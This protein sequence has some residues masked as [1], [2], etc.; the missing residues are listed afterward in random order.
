[1]EIDEPIIS[2]RMVDDGFDEKNNVIAPTAI[3]NSDELTSVQGCTTQLVAPSV[4][5]CMSTEHIDTKE[6]K[7]N[8][9]TLVDL[10]AMQ[11]PSR[12]NA[13]ELIQEVDHGQQ[14]RAC[15]S[16]GTG[17]SPSDSSS[18]SSEQYSSLESNSLS[19]ALE[20]ESD[21]EP[22]VSLT[23]VSRE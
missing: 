15:P 18:S 7:T 19:S 1:M 10:Q 21:S 13:Q 20:F 17:T 6:R 11:T 2:E 16:A 22:S 5:V 3:V 4:D 12:A 9:T 23:L 14:K 8:L